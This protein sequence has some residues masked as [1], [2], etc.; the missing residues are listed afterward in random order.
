[1]VH[2]PPVT[3]DSSSGSLSIVDEFSEVVRRSPGS[4]AVVEGDRSLT[5]E[6]L[7]AASNRLA[8]RL[9]KV[10]VARG[11]RVALALPRSLDYVVSVLAVL[12][13]GGVYVPVDPTHP[14][15]RLREMLADVEAA[16]LV[17]RR[18]GPRLMDGGSGAQVVLEDVSASEPAFGPEHAERRP[19]WPS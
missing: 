1:M 5:Y 17:T 2:D 3:V 19:S 18:D 13:A 7:D 8:R 10:G 16:A 11:G 12:K 9:S 15:G 6:E 4:V 14:A